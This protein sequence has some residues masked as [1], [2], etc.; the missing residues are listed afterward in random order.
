MDAPTVKREGDDFRF[1]WDY[2]PRTALHVIVGNVREHSGDLSAVV[3]VNYVNGRTMPLIAPSRLNL[4][5]PRS[6]SELAGH[7]A[8]RDAVPGV[9]AEE[10]RDV[11]ETACLQT[12][13]LWERGDAFIDLGDEPAPD[14]WGGR[15][16]IKDFLPAGETTVVFADG[17]SGKSSLAAAL[18]LSLVTGQTLIPGLA[19]VERARSL[20]LDWESNKHEHSR[21]L[22]SLGAQAGIDGIPNGILYRTNYRAFAEDLGAFRREVAQQSIGFVVVDSAVPAAGDDI[23]DTAAPRQLFNG[24]R[25][26]GD[27]VTR[28]VLAHMSKAEAEKESGR[29]RVM[30]SVMFEN[31]ARSVVEVRV[32]D[33]AG[34]NELV[35][36]LF[37][38]KFNGGR[39]REPFALRLTFGPHGQPLGYERVDLRDYPDLEDRLP[40]RRRIEDLLSSGA[41]TT[42]EV[43]DALGITVDAASK[44]LRRSEHVI[45]LSAGGGRGNTARWGLRSYEPEDGPWFE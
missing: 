24:L 10:W 30:G 28:L 43:A 36:G 21:R 16:L 1:V 35:T 40:Q 8:K 4:V 31:L 26:L 39:L 41:R 12:F 32:S 44:A 29:S 7:L 9:D 25:A 33:H 17:G 14:S 38:R 3:R 22:H 6:R 37:H 19:P 5:A 18:C 34:P 45:Q 23:K 15:E 20:Y 11:I 2:G 42:R 27:D 13:A